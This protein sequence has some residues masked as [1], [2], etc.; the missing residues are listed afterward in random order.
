MEERL[1]KPQQIKNNID[2]RQSSAERRQTS[3]PKSFPILDFKGRR[4]SRD[5]RKFPDRRLAYFEL[6]DV[7][8]ADN[9]FD[10][11]FKPNNRNN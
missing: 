7:T 5:R 2:R 1:N 11:L 8:L 4:V 9:V 6:K 10:A 3:W